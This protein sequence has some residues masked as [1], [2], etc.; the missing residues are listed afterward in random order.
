MEAVKQGSAAVGCQ[1]GSHVVLAALKRAS[2]E[3]SSHQPKIF[4]ISGHM[5]V[6]LSG[7]TADGRSLTKYMQGECINHDFVYDTPIQVGR[8]VEQVAD[9]SQVKTARSGLRPYGVGLLVAGYDKTGAHLY[10]TCPSGN[11]Y[12]YR[13]IAI[14]ARS[15][16]AKTYL[17]KTYDGF[18]ECSL[19]ELIRHA[20]MALKETTPQDVELTATNAT[21]AY[22]GKGCDF[23]ILDGEKVAPYVRA[24][25]GEG[26]EGEGEAGGEGDA[27]E[28]SG[29]A[30]GG[31]GG[32]GGGRRRER[33]RGRGRAAAGNGVVSS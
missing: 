7:L 4:E 23:T 32:G 24:V 26:G 28:V 29:A 14:G 19:D 30:G 20:L 5:G 1:S 18:A 15:Q 33:G 22:V 10:Q 27:M 25:V 13:A 31:A 11:Y 21:V 9:K 8:L 6:A 17:E 12:E 2:S 3:L 16:A